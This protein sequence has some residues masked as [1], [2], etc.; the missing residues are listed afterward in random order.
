MDLMR[1]MV[2]RIN[3]N[4]VLVVGSINID[5]VIITVSR[6]GASISIPTADEVCL[7]IDNRTPEQR[8]NLIRERLI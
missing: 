5:Y 2:N 4:N 6:A 3:K 1:I 8:G 7:F